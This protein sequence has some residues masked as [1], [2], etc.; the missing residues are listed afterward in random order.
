MRYAARFLLFSLFMTLGCSQ[1]SENGLW[2]GHTSH[3][4]EIWLLVKNHSIAWFRTV[5][6]LPAECDSGAVPKPIVGRRKLATTRGEGVFHEGVAEVDGKRRFEPPVEQTVVLKARFRSPAE[7][8]GE[9]SST[10]QGESGLLDKCRAKE[11]LTWAVHRASAAE[12]V[13][14]SLTLVERR[15]AGERNPQPPATDGVWMGQTAEGAE[16]SFLL[17]NNTL[18]WFR[19]GIDLPM[20][21]RL[22]E[23]KL[24][25]DDPGEAELKDDTFRA[26]TTPYSPLVNVEASVSGK[27]AGQSFEGR[28]EYSAVSSFYK[29]CKFRIASVWSAHQLPAKE[30]KARLSAHERVGLGETIP[31]LAKFEFGTIEGSECDKAP[32]VPA[33][34]PHRLSSPATRLAYRIEVNPEAASLVDEVETRIEPALG[35]EVRRC[36][37]TNAFIGT[38]GYSRDITTL[39]QLADGAVFPPGTYRLS[40][41]FNNESMPSYTESFVVK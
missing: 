7:L 4:D 34:R 38:N 26:S 13:R 5:L 25:I 29:D 8:N 19:T 39:M 9:L 20:Q 30:A 22:G 10:A 35:P 3:G 21:C 1:P 2:V 15:E 31:L 27:K 16:I 14:S 36:S 6:R 32:F 37:F 17:L 12:I 18:A 28:L 11:T 41:Y 33:A 40:V 23:T 24:R